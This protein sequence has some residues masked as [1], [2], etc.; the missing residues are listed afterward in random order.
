MRVKQVSSWT[1]LSLFLFMT[2]SN[3]LD[4]TILGKGDCILSAYI[5]LPLH[6]NLNL[7]LALRYGEVILSLLCEYCAVNWKFTRRDL[8]SR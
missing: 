8:G 5:T 1:V 6:A 7:C 3:R 4:F 2:A